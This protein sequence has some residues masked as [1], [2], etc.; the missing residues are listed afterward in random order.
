MRSIASMAALLVAATPLSV[1]AEWPMARH[2]LKRTGASTKPLEV[3][4]PVVSW[5]TYLG[6]TL[7]T[8]QVAALD[9]DGRPGSEVLLISGG[10]LVAKQPDDTVLWETAPL[11]LETIAHIGDFDGDGETDV[12][13]TGAA[14]F[15]GIFSLKTGAL[16]WRVREGTY[17]TSIIS[18]RL[19]D[20]NRDGQVDL[21]V[22][23]HGCGS[24]NG[25][26]VAVAYNFKGGYR[27]DDGSQRL[28]ELPAN[29]D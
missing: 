6:G 27:T 16:L 24:V 19:A 10:K 12:I 3:T 17:G 20:F 18:V 28:W 23:D 2:D 8:N 5:R 26:P 15:L 21:Y 9:I 29:R 7:G 4:K 22:S 25:K 1:R 13:A 11:A 14:A